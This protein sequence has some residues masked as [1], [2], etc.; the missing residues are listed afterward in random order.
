MAPWLTVTTAAI[1]PSLPTPADSRLP[2][3]PRHRSRP[4]SDG[5]D[6][7]RVVRVLEAAQRSLKS[8]GEPQ[9][10][11]LSASPLAAQEL[12][13]Q[14]IAYW[15][16]LIDVTGMRAGAKLRVNFDFKRLLGR[17]KAP[18]SP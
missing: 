6:G 2:A 10:L 11:E 5:H 16:G 18:A 1:R 4:V 15:E 9:A 14:P 3:L 13:L 8:N 17:K 12:V 7:L